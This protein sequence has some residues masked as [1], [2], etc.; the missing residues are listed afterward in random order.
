M[1]NNQKQRNTLEISE[2]FLFPEFVEKDA[3][4]IKEDILKEKNLKRERLE[5][6][7]KHVKSLFIF[8]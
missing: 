4:K 8:S 3:D 5:R 2:G 7:S 6:Y 1:L